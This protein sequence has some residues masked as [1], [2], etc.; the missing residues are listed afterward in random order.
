MSTP[1]SLPSRPGVYPIR[2]LV[3]TRFKCRVG[4]QPPKQ[5]QVAT[6]LR[7]TVPRVHIT[8][9]AKT[10]SRI[11]NKFVLMCAKRAFVDW[12][13]GEGLEEGEFYEAVGTWW[14]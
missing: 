4:Y 14:L 7:S 5:Y 3:P 6:S 12:C 2:R 8:A 9:T 1:L 10:L 13:A 11:E